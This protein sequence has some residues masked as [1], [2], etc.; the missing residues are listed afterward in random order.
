MQKET[1]S[2][3]RKLKQ[4]TETTVINESGEVL[5]HSSSKTFKV[6]KEPDYVKLY[7]QDVL[8]LSDMPKKHTKVLYELLKRSSYANK[9]LQ[10]CLS[11]GLK[12]I[13]A[14]DLGFSRVQSIDN[15][16]SDLVKGYILIRIETGVYQ[17][18]PAFFGKGEWE[19]IQE[20]RLNIS[21]DD[22]TGRTF[23]S[24]IE[25]KNA[26]E[27]KASETEQAPAEEQI[28]G[29]MSIEDYDETES[30]AV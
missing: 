2:K 9:G 23:K 15:A 6:T 25:Y 7:L 14:K 28:P 29:Q 8:Y 5:R 4:V 18:N 24:V 3:S 30:K 13:M 21:Y 17:F 20:L 1:K 16:L 26:Q 27:Q 11:A 12:R 19:D 22:I 10:V